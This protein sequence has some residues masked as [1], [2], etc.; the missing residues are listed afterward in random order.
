M[1]NKVA[2]K[3]IIC[4]LAIFID[5]RSCL[6]QQFTELGTPKLD[7]VNSELTP[8]T[9][10]VGLK[11]D[12]K[13]EP[14]DPLLLPG[15]L[16]DKEVA[17]ALLSKTGE[18]TELVFPTWRK[19]PSWQAGEWGTEQAT[20]T[21]LVYYKNGLVEEGEPLGVYKMGTE[22]TLGLLKDKNGDIWGPYSTGKWTETQYDGYVSYSYIYFQSAGKGD[23]P[24]SYTKMASFDVDPNT[25]K[26]E[27]VSREKSWTR[28]INL[29]P[30]IMKEESVKTVLAESGS[31]ELTSWNTWVSRRLAPFSSY[32]NRLEGQ[33]EY[34]YKFEMFCLYQD[35]GN[36]LPDKPKAVVPA[37]KRP[38]AVKAKTR[39]K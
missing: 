29:A 21:R 17:A 25:H 39:R 9:L 37:A 1:K 13:A 38:S 3:I 32:E 34:E 33:N 19:V 24:D 30:G 16:F 15:N 27:S 23:Y 5:V 31:P 2:L 10:S 8:V 7:E 28:R 36:L 4:T 12:E 20:G 6:A 35:L 18:S 14:L 26:I 22:F 11:F